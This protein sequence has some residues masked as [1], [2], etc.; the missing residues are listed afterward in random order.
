MLFFLS[1]NKNNGEKYETVT[2]PSNGSQTT[3]GFI[4][5]EYVARTWGLIVYLRLWIACWQIRFD[6]YAPVSRH[7]RSIR[8]SL[9][10]LSAGA[11]RTAM[12]KEQ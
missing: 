8:Q 4:E 12:Y 2:R 6:D 7:A 5:C 1:Q 11:V 3:A 10:R 9:F